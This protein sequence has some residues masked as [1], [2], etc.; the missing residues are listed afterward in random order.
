M[1]HPPLKLVFKQC[2][3]TKIWYNMSP[4][5]N[6]HNQDSNL[7]YQSDKGQILWKHRLLGLK[8]L[9][10]DS[11]GAAA[12]CR[13]VMTSSHPVKCIQRPNELASVLLNGQQQ[14]NQTSRLFLSLPEIL[15]SHPS[16]ID[17]WKCNNLLKNFQ[18]WSIFGRVK[19]R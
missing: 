15:L 2:Y 17:C 19:A 3:Q 1:V 9:L 4:N 6:Q 7:T 10:V 12:G 5:N 8:I 18:N 11:G 13:H 14:G 16:V